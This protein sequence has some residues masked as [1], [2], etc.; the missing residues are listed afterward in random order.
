MPMNAEFLKKKIEDNEAR[1]KGGGFVSL[2]HKLAYLFG[3]AINTRKGNDFAVR[4]EPQPE[5]RRRFVP[6]VGS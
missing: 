3:E 2:E 5:M 4:R 6:I 1:N